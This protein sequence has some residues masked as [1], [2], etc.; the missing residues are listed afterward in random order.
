[1]ELEHLGDGGDDPHGAPSSGGSAPGRRKPHQPGRAPRPSVIRSV[2]YALSLLVI[3]V[4]FLIAPLPYV[5]YAPGNPAEIPP[6]IEISGIE[7]TPI[8]GETA[9]LTVFLRD[10]TP[11]SATRVLLD[12]ARELAPAATVAPGGLTPEFFAE[13]RETFAETFD[14]AAAVGAEAAGVDIDFRTRVRVVDVMPDSPADGVLTPG[15]ELLAVE[16]RPLTDAAQLQARTRAA[17]AGDQLTLTVEHGG[18]QREVTVTL[19]PLAGTDQ[20]GL[21]V[22]AETATVDLELPFEVSL[23]STRIGGP[24]AGMMTA[25]TIYDLLAEEDLVAGRTI[26]GTGTVSASGRVGPVG[27]VPEKVRAAAD[28]GADLV[29]VPESQLAAAQLAAPEGFEVIGVA[30]IEDALEALRA[31]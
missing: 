27:G 18:R 5:E 10:A 23:S 19:R 13:Q 11:Y 15:D 29:L 8:Q 4:A 7:T 21:G 14:I 22:L 26:L 30:T 12:P 25:V 28:H 1:M 2:V 24:S 3:V 20:V 9:L 17:D 31:G 6:L 16:G